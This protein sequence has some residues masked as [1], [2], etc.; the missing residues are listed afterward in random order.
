MSI[1]ATLRRSPVVD[2]LPDGMP[3]DVVIRWAHKLRPDLLSLAGPDGAPRVYACPA[4]TMASTC[5]VD[6]A[7]DTASCTTHRVAL[8]REGR[9]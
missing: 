6:W 5:V 2:P 4:R 1:P 7:G 8:E 9:P 3:D